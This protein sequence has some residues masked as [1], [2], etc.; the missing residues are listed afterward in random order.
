MKVRATEWFHVIGGK[1][2]VLKDTSTECGLPC[3]AYGFVR[4]PR[5]GVF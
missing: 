4:A 5:P 2:E 3:P 1:P